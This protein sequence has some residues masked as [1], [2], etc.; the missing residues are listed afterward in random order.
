MSMQMFLVALNPG[1]SQ[2]TSRDVQHVVKKNGG[3]V[4]MVTSRGPIVALDDSRVG[5]VGSH[6]HVRLVGGVSLN[7]KGLAAERLQRIFTENL[8]KQAT[9][10]GGVKS[11]Q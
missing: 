7:P 4:L 3:F 8:V 11:P 5:A 10:A 1:F 6:P 9:L 2:E